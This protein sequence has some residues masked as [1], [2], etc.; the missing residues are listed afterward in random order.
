MTYKDHVTARDLIRALMAFSPEAIIDIAKDPEL[1]C[2]GPIAMKE[3][4][5]L[6]VLQAADRETGKPVYVLW[7]LY[8]ESLDERYDLENENS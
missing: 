6:R 4:G 3:T 8:L 2:A 5:E 1:N 7:P